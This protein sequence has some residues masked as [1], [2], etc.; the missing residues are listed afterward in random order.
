[1][2]TIA[3]KVR[4]KFFVS[5][6]TRISSSPATEVKLSPVMSDSSEE[7]KAFWKA[8]PHGLITMTIANPETAD[9]FA[10][11]KEVYVDFTEV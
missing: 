4:A 7:N 10:L 6:I 5:S 2:D 3:T 8:T 11:E 9:F 1:M